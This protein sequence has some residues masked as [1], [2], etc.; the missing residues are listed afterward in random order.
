MGFSVCY[1]SISP[2]GLAQVEAIEQA[3]DNLCRG[4]TW[5]GCEPVNFFPQDDGYLFGC[6]KPNFQ[7]HP[8]DAASAARSG[9]PNGTTRDLLD[10]LC[11]L[12]SDHGIDW[13]ISHDYSS[14][15]VGYIRGGVCDA[16]VLTQIEAFADLGDILDD[17]LVDLEPGTGGFPSSTSRRSE[18]DVDEDEDEDGGPSILA[19]RPKGK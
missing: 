4:R 10:V 7:P 16:E 13:E 15:P 17:P 14:G 18:T 3:A 2:V 6:S 5:L 1:R 11:Q 19:F 9:L 8:D 12:S